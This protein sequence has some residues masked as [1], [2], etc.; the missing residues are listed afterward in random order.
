MKNNIQNNDSCFNF[1]WVIDFSKWGTLE[2]IFK[3]ETNINTIP[4]L[5]GN[6]G[7]SS[8]TRTQ[9]CYK[10]SV[11]SWGCNF[12]NNPER[13]VYYF[14]YNTLLSNEEQME[15]QK[16]P[17]QEIETATKN[18][19]EENL[20]KKA[21]EF[22][23][24]SSVTNEEKK[25]IEKKL[26]TE[27]NCKTWDD[28]LSLK[29]E[30]TK[31]ERNKKI[32]EERN[33]CKKI[34]ERLKNTYTEKDND[35]LEAAKIKLEESF[36]AG[37][38][39]GKAEDELNAIIM[40]IG[41]ERYIKSKNP[42]RHKMTLKEIEQKYKEDF[43][44]L[45][46]KINLHRATNNKFAI[47][48]YRSLIKEFLTADEIGNNKFLKRVLENKIK[49]MALIIDYIKLSINFYGLGYEQNCTIDMDATPQSLFLNDKETLNNLDSEL[50]FGFASMSYQVENQFCYTKNSR[51]KDLESIM[52]KLNEDKNINTEFSQLIY[53][54]INVQLTTNRKFYYE[55][56][57]EHTKE[58]DDLIMQNSKIFYRMETR[59]NNTYG[60]LD[61]TY[62][63]EIKEE[64]NYWS[65]DFHLNLKGNISLTNI[66][67]HSVTPLK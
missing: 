58:I 51:Q 16:L 40:K 4:N 7:N 29:F 31:S 13:L 22:Y 24:M 23:C 37:L 26:I 43:F 20:Q 60:Q 14:N 5:I 9:I 15:I 55:E 62:S 10:Q 67:E 28:F 50:K 3:G 44:Q 8:V 42:N 66:K 45:A 39:T 35:E 34:E 17:D 61:L 46:E 52:N 2:R 64:M 12:L 47:C 27:N 57:E 54:M 30:E 25:E 63:Q 11:Y 65:Q 1:T 59:M 49:S 48:E 18:K 32:E 41:E 19:A 36:W 6:T 53:R 21:Y 33:E 38:Y 56:N